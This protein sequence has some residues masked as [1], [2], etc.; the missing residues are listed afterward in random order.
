MIGSMKDRKEIL[1]NDPTMLRCY[2]TARKHGISYAR[3]S[4]CEFGSN[5]CLDCPFI[6]NKRRTKPRNEHEY[7]EQNNNDYSI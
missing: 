7:T 2:T 4:R 5:G 3:A 6:H 1:D